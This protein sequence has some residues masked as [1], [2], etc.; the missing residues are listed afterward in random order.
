MDFH[1]SIRG[2]QP[3]N[4]PTAGGYG[5]TIYFDGGFT[6]KL[7]LIEIPPSSID[8]FNEFGKEIIDTVF[9]KNDIV[10]PYLFVEG[11][12]LLQVCRV[13][14][15]ACDVGIDGSKASEIASRNLE[16]HFIEYVPHNVDSRDQAYTLLA[17]W[18]HWY[19]LASAVNNI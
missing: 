16:G 14:G 11:S 2:Y 15:N 6:N 1:F 18:N 10:S 7:R 13:P 5:F 17:L 12:W 8:N 4:E 3:P 9:P 19:T